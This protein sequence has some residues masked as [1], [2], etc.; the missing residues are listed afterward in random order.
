MAEKN[1]SGAAKLLSK[2]GAAK[3]GRARAS[4]MTP[5]ERSEQ[6]R[7]AVTARWERA[8]KVP[9]LKAEVVE[10]PPATVATMPYS[11]YPGKLK[12][13]KIVMSCHVL[14]DGRRVLTQG[15][16]MRV[17]KGSNARN[18]SLSTYLSRLE[19][20]NPK[21]LSPPIPFRIPG[22]PRQALGYEATLLIDICDAYLVARDSGRRMTPSQERIALTADIV[23]RSCA[24][25][26]IIA[27]ID[28]AT[29]YQKVRA[30]RALQM[31]L[32]AFIADDMQ[33][34]ARMFPEEFWHELA[35]LESVHYS[36]R[37]R[38]LRWGKYVMAFVYDAIDP[39]VGKA[40]RD[41]NPDP[42]Y[43]QNHHQWLRQHG[44]EAVRLQIG[45]AVGIM[46]TCEDMQEFK[47]KFAKIFNRAPLQLT[48]DDLL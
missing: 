9:T 14:D 5:E 32:Q 12:L 28:E 31:K 4:T 27:L 41:K 39:D 40:L 11:M 18:T 26:G 17:L 29:G 34:W 36:A 20:F 42:H 7:R 19:G 30:K 22:L 45:K 1:V 25:V 3:G 46:Q 23:I 8:G 43:L 35:R 24:K 13:G 16:V 44:Q 37:H 2:S 33:E 10:N 47:H 6:A 15:E 21:K 48:L 38:P